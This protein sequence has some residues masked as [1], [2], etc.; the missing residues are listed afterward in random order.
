ML[1]EESYADLP[2]ASVGKALAMGTQRAREIAV[3]PTTQ[4]PITEAEYSL[5]LHKPH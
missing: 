3:R 1:A 5:A 4:T 2:G